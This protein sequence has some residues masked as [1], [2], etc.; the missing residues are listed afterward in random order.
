MPELSNHRKFTRM[1]TECDINYT[2]PNT[3]L[4]GVASSINLSAAGILFKATEKL[5]RGCSL[6]ISVKPFNPTTP[7]LNAI[8]EIIRVIPI[9]NNQYEIAATIEGIKGV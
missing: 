8:I 3:G 9:E 4:K 6:E 5:T 1:D 2:H 7:P